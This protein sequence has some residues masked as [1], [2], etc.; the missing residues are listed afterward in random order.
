MCLTFSLKF[1]LLWSMSMTKR[2]CIAIWSL[3]T[4]SWPNAA[5]LNWVTLVSLESLQIR[6]PKPKQWSVLLTTY[7]PRLSSQNHTTLRVTFGP[8]VSSCTKCAHFSPLSM[9]NPSISW[10]SALFQASTKQF[11]LASPQQLANSFRACSKLIPLN[12]LRSIKSFA[13]LTFR[14]ALSSSCPERILKMNLRTLFCTIRMF[15]MNLNVLKLQLS[16]PRQIRPKRRPMMRNARKNCK[17]RRTNLTQCRLIPRSRETI[18]RLKHLQIKLKTLKSLTISTR[19]TW[20]NWTRFTAEMIST[21]RM[22]PTPWLRCHLFPQMKRTMTTV[23]TR[24]RSTLCKSR[25]R[26]TVTAQV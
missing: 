4:Y 25:A 15:L 10:P 14:V 11:L 1:A 17:K 12:A 24:L 22:R 2:F 3:R 26:L 21:R 18:S 5:S 9:H 23:H 16:K 6:S 20:S 19:N 13:C 7:H 8:S